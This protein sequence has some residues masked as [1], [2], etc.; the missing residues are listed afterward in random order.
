MTA[1]DEIRDDKTTRR[2]WHSTLWRA[3]LQFDRHQIT[4]HAAAMTYYTMLALFPSVVL[5]VALLAAFGERK[6]VGHVIDYLVQNGASDAVIAP[7]R[8]LLDSAVAA[9][10]RTVGVALIASLL[11][12]V[13][14]ASGAFAASRRALNVVFGV[15]E[16]RPFV[17]RKLGDLGATLL[18]VALGVVAL[19]L[20]FLGGQVASDLFDALGLGG[21]AA[22]IWS[23]AR[24]PAAFAV[25]LV[26]FAY[27]YAVAPDIDAGRMRIWSP[28]GVIA[29]V[30]WIIASIGFVVYIANLN[31]LRA[32][33][34]F[35]SAV[36]LLLWLWVSNVAL[37]WGAEL[38]A[39]ASERLPLEPPPE[40]PG[41]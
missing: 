41:A 16:R 25:V 33:G 2:P 29:V 28:G 7:V 37:L 40:P 6:T 14:G 4:H 22:G 24:W 3:V 20:V 23:I 12:A 17:G 31:S 34:A 15:R 19:V 8:S 1:S 10:S 27:V 11:L 9:S 30:L 35:A 5:G 26:A 32:Y 21:T 38:N 39:A 18:L 13:Y 36:V